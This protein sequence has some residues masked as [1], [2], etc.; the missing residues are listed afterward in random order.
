MHEE[1]FSTTKIEYDELT[2]LYDRHVVISYMDYLLTK[3]IPFTFAILDIDNFKFINDT[4]GH[5]NGDEVLKVVAKSIQEE[6]KDF[7]IVGRYGGDEFIFIFPE[8]SDYNDV[9]HCGLKILKST[10]DLY[11]KALPDATITYTMGMYDV[12]PTLG[13]MLGIENK[14][15]L[16][17]DI[18]NIKDDNVVV[19]PNGNYLTSKVYYNNSTGE[20]YVYNNSVIDDEY[21]TK[22]KNYAE[23]L[24]DVSNSIIVH[25]LIYKEG[26]DIDVLTNDSSKENSDE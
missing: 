19:F 25:D 14:Y 7:G 8:K 18:F 3:N 24:L 4:Y 15:A 5:L 2:G 13:N 20:Y 22:Y 26:T 10:M 11:V 23:R 6:S 21:I 12:M 17:H 16:G 1:F 9:W